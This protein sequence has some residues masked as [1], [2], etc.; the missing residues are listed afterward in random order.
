[1]QPQEEFQGHLLPSTA[2]IFCFLLAWGIIST[3]VTLFILMW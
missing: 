3:W 1:M 2:I